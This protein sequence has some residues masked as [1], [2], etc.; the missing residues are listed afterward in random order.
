VSLETLNVFRPK[1]EAR[2]NRG[3]S[4]AS[5]GLR[6]K[7][8]GN[9]R[10]TEAKRRLEEQRSLEKR[11]DHIIQSELNHFREEQRHFVSID[12]EE[13][14]RQLRAEEASR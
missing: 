9:K 8:A 11:L 4:S 14:K 7:Q 5:K 13:L 10:V 2:Q 6:E 1:L 12:P 3:L